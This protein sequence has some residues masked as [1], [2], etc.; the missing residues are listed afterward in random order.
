MLCR[1]G[2]CGSDRFWRGLEGLSGQP[3]VLA[4]RCVAAFAVWVL[5]GVGDEPIGEDPFDL[6]RNAWQ[7]WVRQEFQTWKQ[8]Q[9]VPA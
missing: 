7:L 1:R 8:L 6:L 2:L 5:D 3:P 9:A 4:Q